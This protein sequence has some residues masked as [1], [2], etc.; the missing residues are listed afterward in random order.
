M[1]EGNSAK[2]PVVVAIFAAVMQQ[3][4]GINAVAV[5]GG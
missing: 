2:L 5:Y 3:L 1:V 4:S